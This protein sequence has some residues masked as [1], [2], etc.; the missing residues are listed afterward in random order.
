MISRGL[1]LRYI[2]SIFA[3]S[4]EMGRDPKDVY[5]ELQGFQS[6]LSEQKLL[7]TILT[8]P[9]ARKE[10]KNQA[11]AL[12]TT[13]L[14]VSPICR[15]FLVLLLHLNRIKD[16]PKILSFFEEHVLEKENTIKAQIKVASALSLDTASKLREA[17][18]RVSGKHVRIEIETD[19]EIIGGLVAKVGHKVYDGSLRKQMER[20]NVTFLGEA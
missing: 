8:S 13:H 2:K 20:M 4:Q 15:R 18:E 11:L 1:A 19:P 17:L 6:I 7:K 14:E 5:T 9:T 12:L 16:L 3:V 10:V